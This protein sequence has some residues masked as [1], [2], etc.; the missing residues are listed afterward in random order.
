M[1]QLQINEKQLLGQGSF[2]QVYFG[3]YFKMPIAV[4]KIK[5]IQLERAREDFVKEIKILV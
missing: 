1:S 5:N 2:G 4:K 3:E